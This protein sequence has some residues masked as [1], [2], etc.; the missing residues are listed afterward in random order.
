ME[1]HGND[2]TRI[3]SNELTDKLEMVTHKDSIIQSD[4]IGTV[5]CA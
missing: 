4:H 3:L 1:Q 5:K 2:V